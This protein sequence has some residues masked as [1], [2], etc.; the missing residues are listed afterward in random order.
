ME[1][2]EVGIL[3]MVALISL[4]MM[5]LMIYSLI[6]VYRDASRRGHENAGLIAFL[7]FICNWPFSLLF[8]T[9][10]RK[11]PAFPPVAP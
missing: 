4:A 3:A 10:M 2:F 6:W 11:K 9:V 5:G 8:Y 1:Q 7:C